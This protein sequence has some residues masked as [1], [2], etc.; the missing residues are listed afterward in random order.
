MV[1]LFLERK[2]DSFRCCLFFREGISFLWGIAKNYIMYWGGYE[3][4]N[5]MWSQIWLFLNSTN[6][7]ILNARFCLFLT[8]HRYAIWLIDHPSH[9]Y[10][11]H[12]RSCNRFFP[13]ENGLG[14]MPRP[15]SQQPTPTLFHSQNHILAAFH[16]IC[17][18]RYSSLAHSCG[19]ISCLHEN[20]PA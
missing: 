18:I 10:P 20:L 2:K 1:T 3:Y 5:S 14:N 13:P 4:Y 9:D 19:Q 17:K 15:F 11:S 16:F 7:T 6:I 8:I 12:I